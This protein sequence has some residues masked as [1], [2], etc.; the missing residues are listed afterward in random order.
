MSRGL[1]TSRADAKRDLSTH[2]TH[3]VLDSSTPR[4]SVLAWDL[5]AG[6]AFYY[7]GAGF[8][9][10]ASEMDLLISMDFQLSVGDRYAS[11]LDFYGE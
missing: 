2:V 8:W 4:K 5:A 9:E 3:V 6:D 11:N 10:L 7:R 1:P